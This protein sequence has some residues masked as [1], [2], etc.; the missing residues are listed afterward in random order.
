MA[1]VQLEFDLD[2]LDQV[3]QSPTELARDL[4]ISAA[5]IWYARGL[6]SQSRGAAIAGLSRAE[7]IDALAERGISPVQETLA[8]TE[9]FLQRD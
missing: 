5:A 3:Q 1:I 7:F 9:A 6:V 4:R 8:E 2:V